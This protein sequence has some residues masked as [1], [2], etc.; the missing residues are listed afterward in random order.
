MS[1]AIQPCREERLAGCLAGP[2]LM[3]LFTGIATE[4]TVLPNMADID[5]ATESE[6]AEAADVSDVPALL[7][8]AAQTGP[9]RS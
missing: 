5:G 3:D 8:A 9:M 1:T 4:G 6:I 7:G 2:V